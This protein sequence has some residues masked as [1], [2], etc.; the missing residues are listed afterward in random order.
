MEIT[1]RLWHLFHPTAM[2]TTDRQIRHL[3]RAWSKS[4]GCLLIMFVLVARRVSYG[5]FVAGPGGLGKSKTI[6]DTLTQE[7]IEPVLINSHITPLMLYRLLFE[8]RKGRVLWLDDCDS[9]L[10]EPASPWASAVG[11]V[12]T[13]RTHRHLRLQPIGRYSKP[14]RLRE[15]G[16]FLCELDS[17]EERGF[18]AVLSRVDVFQLTA[19]NEE[20]LEQMRILAANGF[21][22]SDGGAVPGSRGLHRPERRHTAV[23]H[24]ALRT[25][26]E[27]SGICPSCGCRLARLGSMPA[28]PAWKA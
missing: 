1:N 22:L 28:R 9:D 11:V 21:G 25:V 8:H 18:K 6:Q 26:P 5:L 20:I 14:I 2:G 4:N 27:E 17:E 7:G 12:G 24:A 19:T 16:D 15:S 3:A 23:E 13:G 10:Y